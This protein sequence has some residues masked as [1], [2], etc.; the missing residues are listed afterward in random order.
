MSGANWQVNTSQRFFDAEIGPD[1]RIYAVAQSADFQVIA[2]SSIADTSVA[3]G[4]DG[5]FDIP[6]AVAVDRERGYLYIGGGNT[7]APFGGLAR[8]NLE[9]DAVTDLSSAVQDFSFD[10]KV[11]G[12]T[13][14]PTGD[15]YASGTI[16]SD[17][18]IPIV[19]RVDA[20][21]G[22]VVWSVNLE[23]GTPPSDRHVDVVFN[24]AGLFV[25]NPQGQAGEKILQLDPNNGSVLNSFGSYPQD[26]N[27]PRPGELY[28]PRRFIAP[29]RGKLYVI[30]DAGDSS[31]QAN[32]VDNRIVSFDATLTGSGWETYGSEGTGEG[33]FNFYLDY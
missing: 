26:E 6:Q 30:D 23:I 22:S 25:T 7:S 12:L 16:G 19:R 18:P 14:G 21:S 31:N 15:V 32:L 11:W 2:L 3:E 28:A 27:A 17:S 1:G 5:T 4:W 13:V 33:E 10:S 24:P 9:N 8:V 29:S 20:Q